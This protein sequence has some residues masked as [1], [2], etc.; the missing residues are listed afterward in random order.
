[1]LRNIIRT[2]LQS[3]LQRRPPGSGGRWRKRALILTGVTLAF[4]V[5]G[6]LGVRFVLWPQIEKSKPTLERL[7][8]ARL[9]TNVTMD[10]VQVSWT[11]IRP[12]FVIAGL[13][14]NN[15]NVTPSPL[16]IQNISGQLSWLSF[17]YT[18]GVVSIAGIPI[19]GKADDFSTES[20]LLAQNNIQINNAKI[21]WEDQQ[22]RKLKTSIDIQELHL[23]NGIRSHE[24]KLIA[25]TPWSSNSIKVQANFVHHLG[26][27]AGNWHDWVGDFSWDLVDVNLSQISRDISLP[28]T[29]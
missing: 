25:Q 20:W 13:R 5:I 17:Y 3:V 10:E 23:S 2:R 19:H 24:G 6:H 8:S 14:F 1:M 21:F 28:P 12:S 22:G 4:F 16:L 26:G 9:G 15:S 27:Q 18:K 11:G 7:M 29:I